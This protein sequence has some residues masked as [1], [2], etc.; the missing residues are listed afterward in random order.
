MS[1]P[2]D[3]V[4]L[5]ARITATETMI[6][7]FENAITALAAG[8]QSYSLNTGQTIQMVTR[9]NLSS[10]RL[11]LQELETRR[12]GYMQRLHGE[13]LINVRPGF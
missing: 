4:W 12:D 8:A 1:E 3:T 7:A 2:D 5:T 9:S 13:G 11:Q 10:M 6:V